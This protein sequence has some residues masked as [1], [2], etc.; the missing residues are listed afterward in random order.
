MSINLTVVIDNDEAIRKFRELQKTAK[1]VTSSVVTDADRM[2][3]AMRRLATTLGQI[4]VGVSLAGLVKQIAQTRGEFQQ[5]EVAF[6]TL[7][8]SKEKADA[9]M[10][11]MVELAAKTPF[12][13]QGVASGARQLLAYGFAAADITD[14]LT[15][16]GNVAAG[17]GLNLQDLTWLYGTTAVQ[18]RLYTRDVM[19]FQSR[20]I[21]LAGELATQLGKTR[22][23][24]SQMVTEGKIG[25]PEVQKAI[26]S[27]TNE[28]GKFHNLMQEQS[29][30]ITGLISN[31][32][33]ALDMMF[34]DLGKSQEGV[35]TGVLKGTISLVENYQ[36]VLDILIPLVSAYGAYKATLILTAAAQKIVVTAANIKAFFDLAKGITAAKDAQLL[37]NTAFNANPLG[38]ALSVLTAIGIAVWKY[39]DGIYSAAKSQKQLNDSIAE[40]A[41]SAAVEQSKL[42]RLKGKLQ[43]AKEGTEEYNK[44]RNEIIEKFGK[45]DAGLKAETL[46]V[47]TLAQKYNSLTDA[48]LQSYNARQYEKFSREQTDLFEQTATKSYDKIFN[49]LIKKYGDELGTQ[50]GVEL[51]KAISDGSIKVLQNSAGILRISG[52]KDFEATIGGALGL[53]T[54]F[55]VYTGRVAKLIANIVE[56]Q[57]VLRETDDLARKRF[58]IT[59]PTPQSSTNTETPEQPKEVRNKSYWEEQKKEAEAALEAMDVSLKG[60]AKWNELIAKIAEYDSKIKQYSVSGK[61]ETDAAKAQ[62]EL[63]DLILA[64]D[65]A[66]QQSRIDILKDGKQKELA[67]IDLRTKEEMNKLEQDKSK[68]KAAQG[69]IITAD[70]TKYF[71]ERQSNIQQKNADDRAAIE[72]KYAQELDKIYKQITDDTLSEEDR[73]IKGIKDKYE[74]FRKWVEDALKAGNITKEQATDLGIKIDQA[75]IAASLNTIVEKYGT[76]EDKIAKIREKHAKDRETATKNGRSD[77]IPQIDKHETEEIGQIKVDELMKTDDWINLFQNLDALSSREIRRIIDNI[78]EQLKNADF[79]PINLKAITDQL[80]QAAETAVKKNPFS[81]V[82]TGFRDYK[83][84]MQEAV[85]L[86]EKYNQTQKE[87]DKQA[88]D[89]AELNAITKKQKAWQNAQ[90]AAAETSQLI[91]AVSGMLGNM[92]VDVPAEVEGLMGALDSFASM[93]I[94]KPFSIVTGAIGGIANL[95]GGIFGGGDRRKERN[96]QRLQDQ[97]DAL[98]KSYDELG[99]AI[100]EAYSTDASELIEQQNELLE[101]QKILIQNQ[102]AEERSKKDTDEERIKEW[103]N[104]I[105]EINKQIEENKEKALDA[106]F[107]EDLKSAIDNFATAYADAWANGE[108]RARTAR[109]VVRN[110]MRQMVIESIKSAIQSSEAMKKFREKL[111]EF[112]LDGVFSAEEQEEAYKMADDLQKYLDD[113]YGWAGSL[114]SDNQASTQNATS[115]G[116]QAMSQ[117]TGDEL[118]GRF[119][120]MQGKMNILV[121]GMELL[122]SINMDTRNVTFDIRDIMIQLNGNVADIRTY[123]RILP[124]M[125]ETLVAINRKLDNL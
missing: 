94:T 66:L 51:Q 97:I 111:Q 120:D 124:A 64:N 50:Y 56:A 12:D 114:L 107:G 75:E 122:R 74:E 117:D 82:V 113:K 109:D 90:A 70:Q 15:R 18:G 29:K 40:A 95:I 81:N 118:N 88:A 62:E 93:D 3:I 72:L 108:D 10:S 44:I 110:M 24:I 71:Q 7:L 5:L 25:F 37:F 6:A 27:M 87:S 46:T 61:T 101:Q 60:T 38:L 9:L 105:D 33:D 53:T 30:T 77:L 104:Q 83:K 98:E 42:G 16:L 22:A 115:R 106:I 123:T 80:D 86:R 20:G 26:E 43:A 96:I 57:E 41:S 119:T 49:K 11:Q 1:T 47:E 54:Q 45:Y 14:T 103:E 116:F 102:I 91:G 85:R 23:E 35:I 67:E 19:Q 73:R 28:G 17:L 79:D 65:K 48:I 13:L 52:L 84:A 68:L 125:G 78:N 100:E 69:G 89:Q 63:S 8:Q 76:M 4:G 31:L 36:K 39:S 55:E 34:N 92:G 99:E 2:D 58:G 112:W 32:G 59:A 121:N 21:D